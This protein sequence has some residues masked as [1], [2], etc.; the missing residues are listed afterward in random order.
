MVYDG[1]SNSQRDVG[2][3]MAHLQLTKANHYFELHIEDIGECCEVAISVAKKDYPLHRFPG[4]N[5]GSIGY[6]ADNGQLYKEAGI[7]SEFGP[8]CGNGDIMGCGIH[9]LDPHNSTQD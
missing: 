3:A 4:W 7:G 8:K 9:F 6:H 5:E 2:V 1:I